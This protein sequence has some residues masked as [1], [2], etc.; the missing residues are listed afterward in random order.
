MDVVAGLKLCEWVYS[1]DKQVSVIQEPELE[2]SI[3]ELQL[4]SRGAEQIS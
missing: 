3:Y 4:R 1:S 2:A